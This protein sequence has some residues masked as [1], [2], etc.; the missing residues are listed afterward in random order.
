MD[1][2]TCSCTCTNGV[3][4]AVL[5]GCVDHHS[6]RAVREEIDR[7]ITQYQPGQVV[8]DMTDIN[9]MDSSGLGLILGRYTRISDMGGRLV[10]RGVSDEIM[11][12]ITLS[13]IE[14]FIPV[15]GKE[16]KTK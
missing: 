12:I 4:T 1:M 14:K 2:L 13:G 7:Q 10:L 11:R 6:V 15:E 8:L 9:F 3:L 5:H 16:V